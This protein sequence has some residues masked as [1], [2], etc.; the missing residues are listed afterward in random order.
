MEWSE[1]RGFWLISWPELEQDASSWAGAMP[2]GAG[3]ATAPTCLGRHE[4][5]GMR[6]FEQDWLELGDRVAR[7]L[8]Y[9]ARRDQDL[10]EGRSAWESTWSNA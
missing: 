6:Q 2:S 9:Q 3:S 1:Q 4:E 7:G 8:R 5:V 10:R